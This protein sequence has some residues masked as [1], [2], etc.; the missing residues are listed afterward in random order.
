MYRIELR[1]QVEKTLSSNKILHA[2]FGEWLEVLKLDPYAANDGLVIN[3]TYE[4]YQVYKKRI[5]DYRALF[6]IKEDDVVVVVHK[7]AP[8]GGAYKK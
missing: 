4:G 2:R 6:I 5:G 8:R 1:K 7:L 3:E